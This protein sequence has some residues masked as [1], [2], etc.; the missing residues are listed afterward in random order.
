[1]PNI[2]V[3]HSMMCSS[4]WATSITGSLVMKKPISGRENR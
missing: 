4:V 2:T 3:L 1:M